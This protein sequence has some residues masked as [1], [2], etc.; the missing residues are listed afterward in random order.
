MKKEKILYLDNN[1]KGKIVYYTHW[2]WYAKIQKIV[3]EII[4][5]RKRL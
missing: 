3:C 4:E 1:S 2:T 5:K